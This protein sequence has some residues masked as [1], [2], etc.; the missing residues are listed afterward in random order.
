LGVG[1][2]LFAGGWQPST[3]EVAAGQAG[4]V[5]HAGPGPLEGGQTVQADPGTLVGYRNQVGKVFYFD[6]RGNTTGTVY[7]TDVYTDDSDLATAAVH[8]GVLRDGE[9]GTV[10]VT[11]LAGQDRYPASGRHGVMSNPWGAWVG[12]YTVEAAQAGQGA[13]PAEGRAREVRADPG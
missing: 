8:A 12:S 1:V 13:P 11:I 4:R 3:P 10:K 5:A 9:R 6:V 7:G 2:A